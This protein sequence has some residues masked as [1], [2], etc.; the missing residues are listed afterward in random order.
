MKLK[1]FTAAD[2][3]SAMQKIKTVF[4]PDAVILSSTRVEDG[5]EVVVDQ[6]PQLL[7]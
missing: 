1:R 7:L 6:T 5:V 2:T 4:G 3:R